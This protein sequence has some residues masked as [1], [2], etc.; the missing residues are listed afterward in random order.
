M[1][2]SKLVIEQQSVVG[3]A[4]PRMNISEGK[5]DIAIEKGK[6][7]LKN[8]KLG[9]SGDDLRAN[10][11]GD[12]VLGKTWDS[13]LLNAK[14]NFALSEMV[15]KALVLVDALLTPGKQPD[16]SY[17]YSLNGALSG[18]PVATPGGGPK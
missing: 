18:P 1:D 16:G 6:L 5:I 14:V 10:V 8:V 9:K 17:T 15:T 11:T 2:L 12:L 3:F 7:A 4:L 13:S